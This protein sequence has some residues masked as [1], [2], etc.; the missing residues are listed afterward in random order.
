MTL[1][2]ERIGSFASSLPRRASR[3][4]CHHPATTLDPTGKI[5]ALRDVFVIPAAALLCVFC[6]VSGSTAYADENA[7]V[8]QFSASESDDARTR[9]ERGRE[10]LEVR[11]YETAFAEYRAALDTART[12]QES[13]SL[14][15]MA[16]DGF[17]QAGKL[18]AEQ[19]IAEGR[20]Q[21]AEE[22]IKTVL[23]P[24]YNPGDKPSRE[25]LKNLEDPLYFNKTVTPEFVYQ[26]EQV[27]H[28]LNVADGLSDSGRY[29]EAKKT[30]DSVLEIDP[31]NVTAW[32]GIERINRA[33]QRVADIARKATAPLIPER[34]SAKPSEWLPVGLLG[35][36]VL[37]GLALTFKGLFGPT[38]QNGLENGKAG[39][40]ALVPLGWF[41]FFVVALAITAVSIRYQ[42]I[43]TPDQNGPNVLKV[44]R[45]TGAVEWLEH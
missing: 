27:K 38:G 13:G 16:L 22:T 42:I 30:L 9:M 8:G 23:R 45:W 43:F 21:D 37:I 32:Q 24:E 11:D 36:L 12:Q 19:R 35:A 33:K 6:I 29:D 28:L 31:Y 18:L 25:L 4:T 5:R 14:R 7:P 10:A 44:D 26:V 20:W 1:V 3:T 17:T 40:S 15:E 39:A 2:L 34:D 41:M